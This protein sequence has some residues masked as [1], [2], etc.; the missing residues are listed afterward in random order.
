MIDL[1][2]GD[3]DIQKNRK[4]VDPGSLESM[5]IEHSFLRLYSDRKKLDRFL[6]IASLGSSLEV[7]TYRQAIIKDFANAPT[8]LSKLFVL[9]NKASEYYTSYNDAKKQYYSDKTMHPGG[10]HAVDFLSETAW[11]LKKLLILYNEIYGLLSGSPVAS[12]GLCAFKNELSDIV[13]APEYNE[14]LKILTLL[15]S[16]NDLMTSGALEIQLFTYANMSVRYILPSE[17]KSENSKKS[18]LKSLFK[19][20]KDNNKLLSSRGVRI[21][22]KLFENHS[23]TAS[24]ARPVADK[25]SL[26]IKSVYSEITYNLAALEFYDAALSYVKYLKEHGIDFC[27]PR[28]GENTVISGLRDLYLL[29]DKQG[30]QVIPNDFRFANDRNGTLITGENGSGKTVYLRS[31]ASSCLLTNAGLP[32]PASD[33]VIALPAGIFVMMASSERKLERDGQGGR[34][35]SEVSDLARFVHNV[36]DGSFVFLNEVF[37]S[38]SYEDGAAALYSVLK[39]F[40]TK[41]VKWILVTHFEQMISMFNGDDS[42]NIQKTAL[43][44]GFRFSCI[45]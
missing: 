12:D 5:R 7:I 3:F 43:K 34:F 27:Y 28:F 38:T 26:I 41:H 6:R 32:I 13:N 42:V 44:D 37:Q 1:L 4:F 8:L 14:M 20:I 15:E 30:Q 25:L 33:A 29:T 22:A 24:F 31:I 45:M 17:K 40:S 35:E 9:L 39:H 19:K 16:K 36:E 2:Y 11:W 23:F 18:I 10:G 21:D